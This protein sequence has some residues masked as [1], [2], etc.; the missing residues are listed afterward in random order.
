MNYE[1]DMDEYFDEEDQ[2]I[3]LVDNSIDIDYLKKIYKDTQ[4]YVSEKN[5]LDKKKAEINKKVEEYKQSLMREIKNEA[6]I[7]KKDGE[8]VFPYDEK[9]DKIE[10]SSL[11]KNE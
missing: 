8:Y 9:Y 4:K 6:E 3:S 1:E 2:S 5:E 10:E 7:V 11:F